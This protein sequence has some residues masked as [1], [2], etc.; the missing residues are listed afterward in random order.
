MAVGRTRS[1]SG[2]GR[3][4]AGEGGEVGEGS[5][6]VGGTGSVAILTALLLDV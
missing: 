3:V 1:A 5:G 6:L 2:E 4:W